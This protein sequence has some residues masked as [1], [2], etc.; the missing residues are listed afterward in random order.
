MITRESMRTGGKENLNAEETLTVNSKGVTQLTNDAS[1][2]RG[3]E[4]RSPQC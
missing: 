3:E 4:S 1:L 2:Q